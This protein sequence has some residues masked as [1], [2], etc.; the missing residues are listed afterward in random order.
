M[1]STK[2][3]TREDGRTE[4]DGGLSCRQAREG[5]EEKATWKRTRAYREE[6]GQAQR[7]EEH[8]KQGEG[9]DLCPR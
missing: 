6:D 4:S 5:L 7:W 1:L 9:A 3:R 2:R 8:P